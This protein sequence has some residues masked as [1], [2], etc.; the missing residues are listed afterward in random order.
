MWLTGRGGERE[1]QA[2]AKGTS[3]VG[4]CGR[5]GSMP[6]GDS[7]HGQQETVNKIKLRSCGRLSRWSASLTLKYRRELKTHYAG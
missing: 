4:T 5:S 6:S 3:G 2:P 1:A 7:L